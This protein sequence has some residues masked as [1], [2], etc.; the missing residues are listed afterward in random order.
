MS[1]R[2]NYFNHDSISFWRY[3]HVC[4]E[5]HD[6]FFPLTCIMVYTVYKAISIQ[7][8]NCVT[9]KYLVLYFIASMH[10]LTLTLEKSSTRTRISF[11][12]R[13]QM[14][15]ATWTPVTRRSPCPPFTVVAPSPRRHRPSTRATQATA[16]TSMVGHAL[17]GPSVGQNLLLSL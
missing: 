15:T 11:C 5:R 12:P 7:F 17:S 13:F 4:I 8:Y 14:E 6:E 16:A 3:L 10:S 1:I 2:I 9:I